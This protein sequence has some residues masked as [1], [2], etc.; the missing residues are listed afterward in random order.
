[1]FRFLSILQASD[2][3]RVGCDQHVFLLTSVQRLKILFLISLT[4]KWH[5]GAMGSMG[6]SFDFFLLLLFHPVTTPKCLGFLPL[7]NRLQVIECGELSVW[8]F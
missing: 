1:M 5:F 3:P 8:S 4:E 2:L 6:Q 7:F